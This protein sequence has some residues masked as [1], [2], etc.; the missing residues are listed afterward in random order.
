MGEAIEVPDIAASAVSDVKYAE[1]TLTP[2]HLRA[3]YGANAVAMAGDAVIV[4]EP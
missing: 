3:A 1:V 2:G 4:A